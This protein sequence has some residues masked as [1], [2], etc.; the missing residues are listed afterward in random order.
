[1]HFLQ[2]IIPML[3]FV[4]PHAL[5]RLLWIGGWWLALVASWV[6]ACV[7]IDE[8][9]RRVFG[10]PMP[11][12]LLFVTAGAI[13]QIVTFQY[14]LA[15]HW[16][17]VLL[18]VVGGGT[19]LRRRDTKVPPPD[20]ILT[21]RTIAKMLLA[22]ATR[23]GM[24]TAFRKWFAPIAEFADDGPAGEMVVFLKKDGSD[25]AV[26]HEGEMSL[27]LQDAQKVF[28][29]A[30]RRRATDIQLE[31]KADG[32]THI[33]CRI[34]G[35]MQSDTVLVGKSGPAVISALKV[36]ADMNIAERRR[37]QDGTFRVLVAGQSLE[38]RAATAPTSYGEKMAL[39]LLDSEGGVVKQGLDG[40]GLEPAV[41]QSLRSLIHQP[42]GMLLVCGPTGSGKTTT[43]YAA[44]SEID[45]LSRNIVTIEDPIECRLPNISQ[46]GVNRAANLTFAD[47]LRSLLRQDP[48]VILVG[49]IR[50]RETAE[51]AMQ[52]ALT[53]HFVFS[54]LHANDAA[55]TV[56]RLL[57]LGIDVTLIQTALSAVLAQRL[58][59]VLCEQCKQPYPAP[60]EWLQRIPLPA[61]DELTIYRPS[62]CHACSG[63]GYRGRTAVSELLVLDN[64]IREL[65]VARPSWDIILATAR[66]TGMRTIRESAE[67]L[68]IRGITSIEEVDRITK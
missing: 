34:D 31:P 5:G 35:M 57:K 8:D 52:A 32:N 4:P 47:I 1:V 53:G 51:I 45:A 49:E 68:V 26:G 25:T 12:S 46:T 37:P 55:T 20:R 23:L 10:T 16:I 3:E 67:A 24:E 13:L 56:A 27:A 43:A 44:I 36:V 40:I 38:V 62:S 66:Q 7:W 22:V 29:T 2:I 28:A 65:L 15:G 63:T 41:I 9:A 17:F 14:G 54:T 18:F 21:G 50:D 64:R 42:H 61:N 48:D 33:R 6:T 39:R 58:L 11:W 60:A 59:R 19:Y 30:I